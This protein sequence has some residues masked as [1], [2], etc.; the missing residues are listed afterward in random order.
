M[1]IRVLVPP[2]EA[3]RALQQAEM[4]FFWSA[5][6]ESVLR[7]QGIVNVVTDRADAPD[8]GTSMALVARQTVPASAPAVAL[9]EGPL[10]PA[11]L[12]ALGLRGTPWRIDAVEL[13]TGDGTHLGEARYASVL[14][15]RIPAGGGPAPAP[16]LNRP[17]D[18]RWSASA[19]AIQSFDPDAAWSVLLEARIEGE[20]RAVGIQRGSVVALGIPLFDL[21]A[22]GCAFEPLAAGY[23]Q[24]AATPPATAVERH[25]ADLVRQLALAHG[26]TV[27]EAAPWPDG[28]DIAL[29]VR[30]DCD[31]R[32][33]L[34]RLWRL[35]RFY[36]HR[37]VRA[38]FG[39][40]RGRV[41]R[42]QAWLILREGHEINL[43]S[44]AASAAA[45][46]REREHLE[47]RAGTRV[48]GFHSHGGRGS[49][50]FLGDRLYEWAEQAGFRYAEMLGRASRQPHA[51]NRVVDGLPETR[52]LV[53]P[54]VHYSL[55]AG[56]RAAEHHFDAVA[57]GLDG[58]RAD[59]E[60]VVIMNHPDVHLRELRKLI[61]RAGS[62]GIWHATLSDVAAWYA[63]TRGAARVSHNGGHWRLDIPQPLPHD[64]SIVLR[65]PGG[66]RALTLVR[67]QTSVQLS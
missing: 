5:C 48:T 59:R 22:A 47:R 57:A 23:Y 25:A 26:R 24:M 49:A 52:A 7:R 56:T 16:E 17:D 33:G 63:G 43:H 64:F 19:V 18:A 30:H 6:A 46:G 62:N 20:W 1:Q 2:A 51:V 35:L 41:P 58:A 13:R 45:L 38:S 37:G 10:A 60:H 54:G 21:L 65:E 32:V 40:L 39:I 31:R 61:L 15:R 27:V 42:L 66:Q 8:P 29:T 12:E 28:A 36:R 3:I 14:T 67:G 11:V 4:R 34:L 44:E 53:V 50:G 55:D 9:Y